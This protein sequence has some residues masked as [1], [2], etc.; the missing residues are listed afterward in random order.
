[1]STNNSKISLYKI[2]TAGEVI[3]DTF[4]FVSNNFKVLFK[5]VIYL[6]LPLCLLLAFAFNGYMSA[7]SSLSSMSENSANVDMSMVWGLLG[8][9]GC[10]LL[11][12]LLA[13]MVLVSLVFA[14]IRHYENHELGLLG[15]RLSD[16]K[17]LLTFNLK[18]SLALIGVSLL[19][20]LLLVVV[21]GGL[22]LLIRAWAALMVLV[23]VLVLLGPLVL[24]TPI[25]LLEEQLSVWGAI[26]KALRLGMSTWGKVVGVILIV[27][28]ICGII[29][30]IFSLPWYVLVLAKMVVGMEGAA[31]GVFVG[32]VGYDILAYLAALLVTFA[33][34]LT[35]VVIYVCEAYLYGHAAEKHNQQTA[36]GNF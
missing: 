3:G 32:S 1:M 17:P 6:L 28:I 25:Y 14:M 35:Y 8:Q 23:I 12:A 24:L 11:L 9:M 26:R 15:V 5:Y 30:A 19:L 34:M 2:R 31:E 33:S 18:R 4:A 10:Y 21:I 29:Q 13:Q 22:T 27:A 7:T 16:L 36:A 20:A